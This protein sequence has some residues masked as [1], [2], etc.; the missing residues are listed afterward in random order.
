MALHGVAWRCMALHGIAWRCM[1]RCM[2]SDRLYHTR[3]QAIRLPEDV[4]LLERLN[5]AMSTVMTDSDRDVSLCARAANEAFKRVS[6]RMGVGMQIVE[7]NGL[8]GSAGF[9][10]GKPLNPEP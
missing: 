7:V 8:G 2:A 9:E 1:A 10:V 5:N 3:A 6:V 4:D